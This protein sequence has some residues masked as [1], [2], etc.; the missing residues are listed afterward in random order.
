MKVISDG[1]QNG[2]FKDC[3]GKFGM[4]FKKDMPTYSIPFSIQ[5]APKET[6][7]FVVVLDDADAI[8]VAGFVWI[9]WLIA[10]LKQTDV[11]EN[12]SVADIVDFVQGQN[13]WGENLYGGMAPPNCTHVYDLKVY[14]LD[15]VLSLRDGFT[16]DEL[17]LSMEGHVLAEASLSGKYRHQ[18]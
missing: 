9:H 18:K 12:V 8:P 16:Y 13:S 1:I 4:Q 3:Y 5:D 7:S 2:F 14:A 15:T 10:N 17:K 11:P 6:R